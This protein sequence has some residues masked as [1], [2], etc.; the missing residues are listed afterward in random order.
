[1]IDAAKQA[2]P[3]VLIGCGKAKRHPN[4]DHDVK[5]AVI[6]PNDSVQD[7]PYADESPAWAARDLYTSAYFGKKRN[8]AETV[9]EWASDRLTPAWAILSAEHGI[10]FPDEIVSRYN[11]TVDDLGTDPENPEDRV[12]IDNIANQPRRPDGKV[13]ATEMDM[14]A[15]DVAT[16]LSSWVKSFQPLDMADPQSRQGAT[17]LLVL[18]GQRYLD[19]LRERGT[20]TYGS[21]RIYRVSDSKSG[22]PIQTR[23]L[24][25]EIDAGGNGE[26]MR[27]LDNAVQR[28]K[29]SQ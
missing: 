14:W 6:G 26:Q 9:T 21:S 12:S 18:A 5:K 10:I 11:T 4:D 23:F 15:H 2:G 8:F 22:L 25:E 17:N 13:V 7:S 28:I 29:T 1:M 20:F 19:P 3:L 27:W 16:T 24:F